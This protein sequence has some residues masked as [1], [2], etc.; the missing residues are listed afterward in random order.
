MNTHTNM[1]IRMN[2][3]EV[4][5]T[6]SIITGLVAQLQLPEN[7]VAVAVSNQMVPHPQWNEFSLHED[8]NLI[9]IRAAYG[10]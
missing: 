2:N 10:E 7:G 3:K 1:K 4:E 8:D 5:T 9:V 6:T